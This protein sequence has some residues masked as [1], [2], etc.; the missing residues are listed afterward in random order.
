MHDIEK[1]LNKKI[2]SNSFIVI[3]SKYHDFLN[4]FFYIKI[5]KFSSHRLSDHKIPLMFDKK[6]NFDSIYDIS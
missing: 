1:I 5:N 3:S 6:S 2:Y 4:V